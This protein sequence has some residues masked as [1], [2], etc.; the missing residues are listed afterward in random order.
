MLRVQRHPKK[1]RHE[2]R[3]DISLQERDK[4]LKKTERS[5]S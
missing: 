1:E 3:K 4:E 2:K 5:N